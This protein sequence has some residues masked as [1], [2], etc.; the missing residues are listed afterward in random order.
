MMKAILFFSFL[1]GAN[2]FASGPTWTGTFE[3]TVVSSSTNK[4]DD[5]LACPFRIT[6][7][8]N[9]NL[10]KIIPE[11]L[12]CTDKSGI[13]VSWTNYFNYHNFLFES[14]NG[15]L[16]YLNSRNSGECGTISPTKIDC[17][18][19]NTNSK[20]PL[21]SLEIIKSG[22][23]TYELVVLGNEYIQFKGSLKKISE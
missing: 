4:D 10:L 5:G 18:P 3:G 23:E 11:S 22:P 12:N 6:F 17:K 9:Q 14:P 16:T 13:N 21:G 15:H 1:T 2:A 20:V 7:T 8:R 19:A